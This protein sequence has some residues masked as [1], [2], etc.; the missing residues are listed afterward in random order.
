M[1]MTEELN[2]YIEVLSLLL[3]CNLIAIVVLEDVSPGFNSLSEMAQMMIS[4]LITR[5]NDDT[6]KQGLLNPFKGSVVK[7][8]VFLK[9]CKYICSPRTVHYNTIHSTSMYGDSDDLQRNAVG[10]DRGRSRD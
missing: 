8:L 9:S 7:Y 4:Y 3:V 2:T 6:H 10:L 1:G 5:E